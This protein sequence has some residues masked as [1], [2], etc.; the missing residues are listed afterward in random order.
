MV[1]RLA[2]VDAAILA[3]D[4][5]LASAARLAMANRFVLFSIFFVFEVSVLLLCKDCCTDEI[6]VT[7]LFITLSFPIATSSSKSLTKA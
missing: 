6:G 5:R 4:S 2:I 1:V 3:S 7:A